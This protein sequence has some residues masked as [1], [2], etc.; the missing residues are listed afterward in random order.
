MAAKFNADTLI[1]LAKS[2]R[3]Y[4]ALNKELPVPTSRITD[5]VNELTLHTP[6]SF[7]SQSNRVLVLFG[8]EHDKL[9][10]MTSDILKTIVPEEAWE[11][12]AGRIAGFKAGAGTILFFDDQDVV[13]GMQAQFAAYADKFP[14]WASQSLGMQQILTWTALELEGLGANLQHYN[15]LIDQKVAETW[16][17]PESW[18]LNAQL[19]FGGRAGEPG[20]KDFKPLE[21]RVKVFGQ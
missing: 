11:P 17:V 6:S 2:R 15:P 8:A 4:Y 7:N 16:K 20:D 5:I 9:W 3:T 18:K 21:E 10:D 14:G 13:N 12:T 1:Q 19:V